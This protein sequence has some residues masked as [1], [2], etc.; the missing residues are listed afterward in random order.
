MRRVEPALCHPDLAD[1]ADPTGGRHAFDQDA[2]LTPI[3]TTLRRGGWRRHRPQSASR[4]LRPAPDPAFRNRTDPVTRFRN[5][6]LTAPLPV[7]PAVDHKP[8]D[9]VVPAGGYRAGRVDPY[10]PASF[11]PPAVSATEDTTWWRSPIAGPRDPDVDRFGRVP[12]HDPAA[13]EP[14][15]PGPVSVAAPYD[16]AAHDAAAYAPGAYEMAAYAPA[17]YGVA[18]YEPEYDGDYDDYRDPAY[19]EPTP[20]DIPRRHHRFPDPLSYDP[21]TDS[22]RHH[23]RLAPAGW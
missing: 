9:H 20:Y 12:A 22:G 14:A 21:V 10:A 18:Y 6:P 13:Y 5:D 2:A 8:V 7:V 1:H 3:F 17:A 11:A 16:P 15:F 4:P 23:R 19:D